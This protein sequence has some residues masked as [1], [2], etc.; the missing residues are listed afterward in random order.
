[1]KCKDGYLGFLLE[2][3]DLGLNFEN[4]DDV[5]SEVSSDVSNE[6]SSW[7]SDGFLKFSLRVDQVILSS[8]HCANWG[9]FMMEGQ[10]NFYPT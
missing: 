3:E 5:S 8:T 2:K 9:I 4:D 6:R 1:M 10:A 7:A